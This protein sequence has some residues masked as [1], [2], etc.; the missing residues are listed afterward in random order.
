MTKTCALLL[1]LLLPAS[2]MAEIVRC[3]QRFVLCGEY[4]ADELTE[5]EYRGQE[6]ALFKCDFGRFYQE[7][8][9]QLTLVEQGFLGR[10]EGWD[11]LTWWLF[12]HS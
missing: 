10:A 1:A 3:S 12:E 4:H 6:G 8:F 2:A 9:P 7:R 5:V 11:D